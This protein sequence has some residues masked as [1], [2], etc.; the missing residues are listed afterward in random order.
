MEVEWKTR[1]K[2]CKVC[3]TKNTN[4]CVRRMKE[5]KEYLIKHVGTKHERNKKMSSKCVLCAM[6]GTPGGNS[7][8]VQELGLEYS[9]PAWEVVA[10]AWRG[11]QEEVEPAE[12]GSLPR[13]R[14]P[15]RGRR[16]RRG[17]GRRGSR[18]AGSRGGSPA[19]PW[20]REMVITVHNN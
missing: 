5:T 14:R 10:L 16:G 8:Q 13:S 20:H 4:E 17:G 12:G 1:D 6:K 19:G 11:A 9:T 2:G 3:S 18:S 15:W 7:I